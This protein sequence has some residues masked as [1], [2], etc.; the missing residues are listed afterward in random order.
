MTIEEWIEEQEGDGTEP[1]EE[2]YQV[3]VHALNA[4]QERIQMAEYDGIDLQPPS[5]RGYNN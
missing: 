3:L 2:F 5:L 4:L 1:V